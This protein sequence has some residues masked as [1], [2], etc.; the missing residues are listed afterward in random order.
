M[1]AVAVVSRCEPDQP[2][3]PCFSFGSNA[4]A[5]LLIAGLV[6]GLPQRAM[7]C[8]PN[9]DVFMAVVYG[10]PSALGTT[11]V[12]PLVGRAL[13]TREHSPYW[14]AVGVTAAASGVGVLIAA[15]G[16]D[17]LHGGGGQMI[18]LPILIGSL[19][20]LLVY[21]Y[22]PRR[23]DAAVEASAARS[24][25]SIDPMVGPSTVGLRLRFEIK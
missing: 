2:E 14:T 10:V 18:A 9:C 20:T 15:S 24:A 12:A 16:T 11:I 23:S 21:R 19:A 5:L 25:W 17:E 8:D 22:W 6:C 4:L 7:A 3:R 1:G 13:D